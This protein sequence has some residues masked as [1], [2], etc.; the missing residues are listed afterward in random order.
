MS[1]VA[2]VLGTLALTASAPA[3][4]AATPTIT[5]VAAGWNHTCALTSTGGVK[6]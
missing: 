6:C 5:A 2:L 4:G 1:V 3:A